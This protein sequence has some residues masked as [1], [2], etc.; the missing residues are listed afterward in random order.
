M[1]SITVSKAVRSQ[2]EHLD[3]AFAQLTP[4]LSTRLW[5]L[6]LFSPP[7]SESEAAGKS[8]EGLREAGLEVPSHTEGP[9]STRKAILVEGPQGGESRTT[10]G[11]WQLRGSHQ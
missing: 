8:L 7:A 9:Y 10:G 4:A 11:C 3:K 2:P 1:G 5:E 6:L